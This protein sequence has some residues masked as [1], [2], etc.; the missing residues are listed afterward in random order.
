MNLRPYQREALDGAGEWPGIR[1]SLGEH[2]STLLVLPTG[3]G[4][5]VVFAHLAG[6]YLKAGLRVLII[7]HRKELLQQARQ[8][9][10][11][12]GE[13]S[14][15]DVGIE[16]AE[17]TASAASKVVI[18]SVQTLQGKRLKSFPRDAFALVVVDEAHHAPA[19]SYVEILD[20]FTGADVL[21]VTA[22]PHRLD[23]AALRR[24]FKSLAFV[25]D[26]TRAV[27]E[28]FLA[29]L[30]TFMVEVDGIDLTSCRT[31]AGDFNEGDLEREMGSPRALVGT[32]QPAMEHCGDRPTLVFAAGVPVAH[33]LARAFNER[34]ADCARVVDGSTP[35]D[36]RARTLADFG[37]RRFQFLVNVDVLSEGVDIPC[38]G[39]IV[40]A[41]PT[42][43]WSRYVQRAGR[44]T[45]P[46]PGKENCLILDVTGKTDRKR[47]ICAL[48][49]LDGDMDEEL[50]SRATRKVKSKELDLDEAIREAQ[51]EILVERQLQL[52]QVKVAYRMIAV[53]DQFTLLGIAPRAGRWGGKTASEAQLKLLRSAGV[54]HPEKLD[55]GQASAM[56]DAIHGRREKGLCTLKQAKILMRAG[57]SGEVSFERA[58]WAIERIIGNGWRPPAEVL[59]AADLRKELASA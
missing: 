36:V 49:I 38:I 59:G 29:R 22:T 31:T 46:F 41:S 15:L 6:R 40:M 8:R 26:F 13:L 32:V 57:L 7:A 27:E 30:K 55:R 50:L 45:R 21:G 25:Y 3:T 28:G 44:G 23:G 2:G 42:Q 9:L 5:T 16:Q 43:S 1:R 56:I 58:S 19:K 11:A 54:F 52:A 37:E 10:L 17:S 33:D 12:G 20:H 39:A 24:Q 53:E 35:A 47:P 34:R 48:D 14:Y 18:A 4:K 51:Q